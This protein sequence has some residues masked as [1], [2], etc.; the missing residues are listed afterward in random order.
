MEYIF[1]SGIHGVGKS[2]LAKELKSFIDIKSISVSDLIRQAGKKLDSSNK[3]TENISQNQELWKNELN[4]LELGISKLLLDGHFCLLDV[5]REITP[6]PF[7]TFEN[8]DMTKIIFMKNNPTIIRER[9][10]KRDGTDYPIKLLENLQFCEMQQAM[11]YSTEKGINLFI[12]DEKHP[13]SEL[14]NFITN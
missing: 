2:T 4:N 8:T 12:Y 6:L 7:T 3:K 13:L 11:K 10:L 14:L 1:L 5:K 9:L